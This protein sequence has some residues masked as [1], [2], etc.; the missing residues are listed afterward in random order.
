MKMP[1]NLDEVVLQLLEKTN[2]EDRNWAKINDPDWFHGMYLR[3]YYKLWKEGSVLREWFLNQGVFHPDDM[4]AIITKAF[5]SR[6]RNQ[7]F[8]LQHEVQYYQ[9]YWND[10]PGS[11]EYEENQKVI[12]R[13]KFGGYINKPKKS[14]WRKLFRL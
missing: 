3:N 11:H 12:R 4:S 2:L 9:E 5:L 7:P 10:R 14:W 13:A 1:R 6:I 8:D